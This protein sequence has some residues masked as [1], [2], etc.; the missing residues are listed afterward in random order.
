MIGMKLCD[1]CGFRHGGG[2]CCIDIYQQLGHTKGP[3][4]AKK[5][6][7]AFVVPLLV[8]TGSLILTSSLLSAWLAE[9]STKSFF[10]F[11]LALAVTAVCVQFIRVLTR[12][13]INA[14]HNEEKVNENSF[15]KGQRK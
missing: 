3:S 4:V 13:R 7:L 2:H 10:T 9:G 6:L 14:E 15:L 8:F 11:L 12:K 5:V 1:K